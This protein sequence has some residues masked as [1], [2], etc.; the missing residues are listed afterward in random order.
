MRI[1]HRVFG[2]LFPLFFFSP[3]LVTGKT[4]TVIK[5]WNL[6][7]VEPECL[8]CSDCEGIGFAVLFP[9]SSTG[10]IKV[11]LGPW[12]RRFLQYNSFHRFQYSSFLVVI[13]QKSAKRGN[14]VPRLQ[15]A[16]A[17][18]TKF[19]D[20]SLG[21]QHHSEQLSFVWWPFKS[22]IS[23]HRYYSLTIRVWLTPNSKMTLDID[24]CFT[25]RLKLGDFFALFLT[26][27]K[28]LKSEKRV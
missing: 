26:V 24:F 25:V 23:R 17:L 2:S 9:A 15:W 11:R 4:F 22:L 19:M 3:P 20:L 28:Q 5:M 8:R 21:V 16:C 12:A 10:W 1:L 6:P 14:L 18:H 27:Q 13:W 7:F